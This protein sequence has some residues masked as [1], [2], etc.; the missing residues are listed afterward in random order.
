[1]A[2]DVRIYTAHKLPS[3]RKGTLINDPFHKAL[4][5]LIEEL[6]VQIVAHQ[7]TLKLG[8]QREVDD[9]TIKL[10]QAHHWS[11]MPDIEVLIE[12]K[13]KGGGDQNHKSS[14]KEFRKI[15]KMILEACGGES[16]TVAAKI[17]RGPTTLHSL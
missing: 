2:L 15:V 4:H 6:P 17:H 3:H 11:K 16:L 1:M 5:A 13:F 10:I 9:I 12:C 14:S 8:K 7:S